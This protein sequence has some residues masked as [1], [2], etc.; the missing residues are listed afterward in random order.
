[1]SLGGLVYP[2]GFEPTTYGLEVRCSIQL[3]YGYMQTICFAFKPYW[4]ED[5]RFKNL[6]RHRLRHVFPGVIAASDQGAGFHVV[7]T[8]GLGVAF[9]HGE[10][11]RLNIARYR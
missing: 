3:S 8:H 10:L 4:T 5:H 9:P 1:M 7:E 11:V 2:V 6:R